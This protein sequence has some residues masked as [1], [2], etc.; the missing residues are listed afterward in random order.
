MIPSGDTR[1][2]PGRRS[3]QYDE[4]LRLTLEAR[5]AISD[6]DL[7]KLLPLLARRGTLLESLPAEQEGDWE[8]ARRQQIAEL[9]R[10]SEA[11]LL[12]WRERVVAEFGVLQ[13]GK[14]GLGGYRAGEPADA[15]FI[16]RTS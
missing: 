4:I 11:L 8:Q 6:G 5:D 9:D 14:S 13:R 3:G 10:A 2:R 12:A 7:G 16:D 1:Y 15:A